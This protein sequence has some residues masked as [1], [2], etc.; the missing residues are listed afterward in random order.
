V[1]YLTVLTNQLRG[2]A[3][4]FVAALPSMAIAL[5]VVV[6][7]IFGARLASRLAGRAVGHLHIRNS[8]KELVETLA[9]LGAWLLGLLLAASIVVPG[10]TPASAI[11]GLGIG[12]LAIGFAFQDIFQ[13]FLAGVL[14]MLRNKMQ[15]GDVIECEG[16]QGRV[17]HITLR[18]SHIRQLSGELTIMPNSML[19]KSPVKILT[20][21]DERRNEIVIGLA[22]D[23]DLVQAQA[24]I[25]KAIEG[26]AAINPEKGIIVYAQEFGASSIDFLVQWWA[27]STERDLRLTKSEV[28]FAIK[29]A[30][31][32]AGIEVPYPHLTHTFQDA[33]SIRDRR[34]PKKEPELER[35][36]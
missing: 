1:N 4:S 6:A 10:F 34:A 27:R 20:D 23:T 24:I 2:M 11:A 12:A 7:T 32:D 25:T 21:E 15:I 26:V 22:Y 14:I 17:E 19:F 35:T 18:E 3:A 31:D 8:L 13:N 33:L 16:I 30:L 29:R 36:R 28:I 5:L 9:H